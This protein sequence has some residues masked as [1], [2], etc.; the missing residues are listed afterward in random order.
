MMA[1]IYRLKTGDNV[2]E[3]ILKIA[4][5]EGLKTA[6]VEAIGGVDEATVAYF[7][8]RT[9]Q[10]EEHRYNEFLEVTGALGNITLKDGKPFLH[11]HVT[12]GRSDMS[13]IGGHLLFARVRVFLEV[14]I[15]ETKNRAERKFDKKLGVN[16]IYK[17]T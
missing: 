6:R 17:I 16:A 9:K 2:V 15:T 14:V 11:L 7:N 1:K 10:Y 4:R 13:V 3:E 8:P 5:K 12:L